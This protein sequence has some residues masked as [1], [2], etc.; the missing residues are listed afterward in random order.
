LNSAGFAASFW[1]LNFLS[2]LLLGLTTCGNSYALCVDNRHPTVQ[3]EFSASQYVVTGTVTGQ[4]LVPDPEDK[5]GLL[6]TIYGF[7]VERR[8]K[9]EIRDIKITSENTSGRFPLD[10][11]KRYLLFVHN[12]GAEYY[13]DSCGK[14]GRLKNSYR[15]VR[16]L[17]ALSGRDSK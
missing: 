2:I 4:K 6:A 10:I 16:K 13:V 15:V 17:Q 9:G 3:E 14:S 7:K 8:F 1:K 5:D 11:G 12:D